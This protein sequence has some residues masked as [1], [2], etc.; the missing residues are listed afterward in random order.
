MFVT[1]EAETASGGRFRNTEILT[2][3][4]GRISDVQVF[5][6]WNVPHGARMGS[7]LVEAA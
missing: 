2:I 5:F 6:G 3:S 7:F 1:Y 4:N